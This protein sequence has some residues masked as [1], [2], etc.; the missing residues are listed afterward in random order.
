MTNG[1]ETAEFAGS[2]SEVFA[3]V[4]DLIAN[5]SSGPVR[6]VYVEVGRKPPLTSPTDGPV[7]VSTSPSTLTPGDSG[8]ELEWNLQGHAVIAYMAQSILQD[9]N[10]DVSQRLQAAIAADP[11]NRGD[12]GDLAMWPDKIKHPPPGAFPEYKSKGWIDLGKKTQP[13]H[14]VDIP[15]EPGSDATPQ[16]PSSRETPTILV[17]LPQY[18]QELSGWSD[19]SSGAN[20]LAF[21]IHF[22]GDIH[23]PLH[24]ACL[25]ADPYQPP[26]Y[27]KGGNLLAW[28]NSE[29]NPPSLHKLW[30]DSVAARPADV[31][32]QVA[33]LLSKYP[34][35]HFDNDL[36]VQDLKDWALD[37]FATAGKAYDR[38]LAETK[39]DD[40]TERYTPPSAEYKRWAIEVAQ[41]RAALAAYR[42]ADLL[43]TSLPTLD[44]ISGV[45]GRQ[46]GSPRGAGTSARRKRAKKSS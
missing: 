31:A 41:E 10:A 39:Y 21:V 40:S 34:R 37:S 23:Q 7:Q 28:G 25:K 11:D 44:Q 43:A 19:A 3:G 2:L 12:I 29:K 33:A 4:R 27:D 22:A 15:Y 18:L 14:F 26:D 13:M 38:F 46:N 6:V 1:A 24:C 5:G 8:Y 20:A 45:A 32:K 17:G 30:D 16:I 9:E 35:S 42:L 36:T